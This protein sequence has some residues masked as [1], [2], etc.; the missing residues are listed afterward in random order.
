MPFVRVLGPV[1]VVTA[2]GRSLDLPRASQRRLVALLATEAPRSLRADWICEGTGC[3][4]ERAADYGLTGPQGAVGDGTIPG[5]QGHYRLAWRTS[6]SIRCGTGRGS[7]APGARG[8]GASG[9]RS[10]RVP[11]LPGLPGRVGRDRAI[12]R[13]GRL[14]CRVASG[15]DGVEA[16]AGQDAGSPGTPGDPARW[17]PLTGELARGPGLIRRGR[18]LARLASDLALVSG[19]GFRTVI[20]EGEAGIGMT[21]LLGGFARA[22]RDSGSAGCCTDPARTARPRPRSRFDPC[23]STSSAA[24]A[25]RCGASRCRHVRA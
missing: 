10:G 3:F 19:T 13:G 1:Q 21:T 14:D 24:L 22:V 20:L 5:L 9:R 2:S 17:L 4:C 12:G 6:R 25:R 8:R 11:G 23:S 16:T 15:W 7:V 18:E